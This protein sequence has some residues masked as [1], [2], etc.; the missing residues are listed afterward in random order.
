MTIALPG[1]CTQN[2][3][4]MKKASVYLLDRKTF[5][6][7][8]HDQADHLKVII[9][10]SKESCSEWENASKFPDNDLSEKAIK[11]QS[12]ALRMIEQYEFYVSKCTKKAMALRMQMMVPTVKDSEFRCYEC[13]TGHHEFDPSARS[14]R[15]D[16]LTHFEGYSPQCPIVK[17]INARYL[18]LGLL[19]YIPLIEKLDRIRQFQKRLQMGLFKADYLR[20]GRLQF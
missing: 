19:E 2:S 12:D 16:L 1:D 17:E 10:H 6:N 4:S 7:Q 11:A 5:L 15:E 13:F 20:Y 9:R 14:V 8:V 3:D 18:D